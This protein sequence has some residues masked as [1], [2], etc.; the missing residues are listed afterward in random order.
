MGK[1]TKKRSV[2]RR[3]YNNP[4]IPG[5]LGGINQFSKN[6]GISRKEAELYLTS[7]DEFNLFRPSY[8]KFRTRKFIYPWRL[9]TFCADLISLTQYRKENNNYNYV[10]IVLDCF[11][12]F[13][14]VKKLKTKSADEMVKALRE[15]L[16]NVER[17]PLYIHSD[18]GREFLNSKVK[19]IDL[20]VMKL[21]K[22][23]F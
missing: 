20:K 18:E 11:S 19:V 3:M 5:S 12:K 9:H 21:K 13:M 2:V 17:T 7:F 4:R 8:S 23:K 16:K 1:N 10:L 15:I 22:N 6:R 14:W